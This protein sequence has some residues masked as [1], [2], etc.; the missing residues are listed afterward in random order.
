MTVEWILTEHEVCDIYAK[1]GKTRNEAWMAIANEAQKKL[2]NY[3]MDLL[4][5]FTH[6]GIFVDDIL[7]MQKQLEEKQ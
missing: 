3:Q 4:C 2:L 7:S 6:N 1:E 5:G